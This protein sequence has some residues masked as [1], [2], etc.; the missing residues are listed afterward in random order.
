MLIAS[1]EHEKKNKN[2]K[3]KS[4][5]AYPVQSG[6]KIAVQIQTSQSLFSSS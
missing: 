2:R 6:Y 5:M 4:V 3:A 1:Y